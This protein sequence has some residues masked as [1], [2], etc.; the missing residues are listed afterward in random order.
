MKAKSPIRSWSLLSKEPCIS[1]KE[2]Y[3]SA[4][5]P[6]I[7]D[8]SVEMKAT[9]P[10][11][12]LAARCT[13]RCRCMCCSVLQCVAVCCSVLQCVAV[14]SSVLQCLAVCVAVCVAVCCNAFQ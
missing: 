14:C 9:S 10:I 6:H 4:K 12:S 3:I 1:A 7:T 13:A 8:E 2:P 11:R 5:E